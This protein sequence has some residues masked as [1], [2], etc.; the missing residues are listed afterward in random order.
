MSPKQLGV[1]LGGP[2]K[3]DPRREPSDPPPSASLELRGRGWRVTVPAVVVAAL[4]SALATWAA[5]PQ[6]SVALSDADRRALQSCTD[7]AA[8]VGAL[9][10]E[11][12]DV[13]QEGRAFRQ[14]VEPQIGVLLVRTDSRL[15][16]PPPAAR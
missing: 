9:T 3:S 13:K 15:Y 2:K 5:K 8:A 12:A 14:W 11:V 16:Q 10:K 1:E 7:T 4:V 6:A